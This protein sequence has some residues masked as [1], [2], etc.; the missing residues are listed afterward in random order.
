MRAL[1]ERILHDT[2]ANEDRMEVCH[3]GAP[4]GRAAMFRRLGNLIRGFFGLFLSGLERNRPE[5]LLEVEKERLREQIARYNQGLATHAAL[6]E[7]LM[8]QVK[9]EEANEQELHSKATANLRAG[10][11][12]LAGQYAL[13]LQTTTAEL[14]DH[15]TQLTQ[16]EQTY[17]ELLKARDI[18]VKTAR[19]KLDTLK[20]SIDEMKIAK[21]QAELTEMA[22]GMIGSIAGTGDTLGRLHSMVEEERQKAAGRARVARDSLDTDQ[23]RLKEAEQQALVDQALVDFAAKEGIA[24]PSSR[25]AEVPAPEPLAAAEPVTDAP[26]HPGAQIIGPIETTEAS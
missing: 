13:R 2:L 6:C 25:A 7:S 22:T 14:A 5:A 3:F 9:R 15:R 21:A 16:A 26:T 23:I 11:Q 12:D 18:S 20:R 24:L 10:N 1:T 4:G 19:A 17:Q 8:T